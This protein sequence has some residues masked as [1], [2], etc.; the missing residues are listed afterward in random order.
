MVNI[1][2][3]IEHLTIDVCKALPYFYAF[4]GC[5]TVSSFNGEG[6]CTFFDTRME[7]KKKNDLT[8]TF[9]KP[10]NMPEAINSDGKNTLEFL[11]KIVY[12]GNVKDIENISLNEMRKNQ[13]TQSTSND[14][15][16][17]A[18]SSDA[19][20]MRSLRAAHIA[21]FEWVECLHNVSVPDPSVR[22]YVLK[23]DMFVPKWLSKV[24]TFNVAEFFQTCKCKTTKCVTFK[25]A[26]LGISC[27]PQCCNRECI[28]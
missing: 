4:T 8:K 25:C 6:K 18:P 12:L 13:F 23:D 22:G 27:L 24:S 7:S 15:K 17:I 1:L 16:K 28:K 20:K 14:L 3:L 10:G 5:D 26:K 21:G 9:I 11:V 2:S 19:L